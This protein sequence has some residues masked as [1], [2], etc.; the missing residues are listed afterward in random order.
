MVPPY[1]GHRLS[2]VFIA[3]IN[4][5]HLLDT[6]DARVTAGVRAK[7]CPDCSG[8]LD[9]ANYPRKP[10]GGQV[11]EAGEIFDRRRSLC[12]ARDGCRH[13]QTPPSLLFLGRRVY[14]AITVVAATWAAAVTMPA[15]ATSPP[16]RTLRRWLGWFATTVPQTPCVTELRARLVPALEPDESLPGA[17]IERLLP[18]R[19]VAAALKATLDLLAPL[20]IARPSPAVA[21]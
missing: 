11:G 7:G 19:T 13:R 21:R 2:H 6:E 5:F 3:D 12:C 4:F 16:R 10:R 17:L 18:G 8:R 1:R 20:S 15:A 9:Q 14:L